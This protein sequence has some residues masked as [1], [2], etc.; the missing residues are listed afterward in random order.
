M[1]DFVFGIC[2]YNDPSVIRLLDSLPEDV[3]KIYVDG[4]F[5]W[6]ESGPELT[7]P[8]L[9]EKILSYPNTTIID[10]PNLLEPDKR[11]IYLN[12]DTKALFIIDTDEWI[13]WADWKLF[14]EELSKLDYGIHQIEFVENGQYFADYP[15]I[16]INPKD[17]KYVQCHNIFENKKT[18]ERLR[19]SGT[20]GHRFKSV[21]CSMN[22]HLRSKEYVENTMNYQ[23]KLSAYEKPIKKQLL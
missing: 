15:R 22:D 23:K 1:H 17:W 19:S 2:G 21:Q 4:K 7:N 9:R 14:R 18:G 16:W 6:N 3:P 20:T 8:E 10:A 13:H 12:I 11:E 5:L